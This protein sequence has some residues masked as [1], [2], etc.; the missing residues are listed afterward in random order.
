MDLRKIFL[1]TNLFQ[2]FNKFVNLLID[3]VQNKNRI[4]IT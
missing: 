2:L 4:T 3:C 1:I